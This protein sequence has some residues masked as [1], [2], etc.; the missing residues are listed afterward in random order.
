RSDSG[1]SRNNRYSAE[2]SAAYDALEGGFDANEL[3]LA[4]EA[5]Y[6]DDLLGG[7][8]YGEDKQDWYEK[9]PVTG[10]F[11][12]DGED[13]D[14]DNG[15]EDR[16]MAEIKADLIGGGVSASLTSHTVDMYSDNELDDSRSS[17]PRE[18]NSSGFSGTTWTS[19]IHSQPPGLSTVNE[20]P[21]SR[22]PSPP[23]TTTLP[24]PAQPPP[25]PPQASPV[26]RAK[27]LSQRG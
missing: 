22:P 16:M 2:L 13:D 12:S 19:S 15:E 24:E 1:A 8:V 21:A 7:D 23:K 9:K 25:E 27:S 26:Q 10:F 3:D 11:T 14:C 20:A 5:A 6:G 17:V 4:V 18:S